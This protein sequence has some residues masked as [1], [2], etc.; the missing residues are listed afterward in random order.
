LIALVLGLLVMLFEAVSVGGL[1]NL[2]IPL[3]CYALL[4][5]YL[6]LNSDDLLIRLGVLALVMLLVFVWRRHTTL[7][8]SALLAAA[9]VGYMNWALGGWPWLAVSLLLFLTYTWLWPK[10]PENSRP[11]HTVR[12][13]AAVAA[14]G[15][16]WL[17]ALLHVDQ[18]GSLFL[19]FALAYAAHS[20]M[21]GQTQLGYSKPEGSQHRNLL[22]AVFKSWLVFL[23]VFFLPVFD[24]WTFQ[25]YWTSAGLMDAALWAGIA[26]VTLWGAG[27]LHRAAIAGFGDDDAAYGRWMRRALVAMT[28][29]LA[30]QAL[31]SGFFPAPV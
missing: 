19:P 16:F 29:S 13:V 6:S 30:G 25:H 26:L 4:Q 18:P 24:S 28:A 1:D 20:V 10:S 27:L 17:L 23:P 21:V 14:P 8:E 5:R 7:K 15:L 3:G 31:W 22:Q 11:V 2:F 9:L 12:A